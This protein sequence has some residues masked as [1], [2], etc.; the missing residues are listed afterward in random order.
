M[1]G[2]VYSSTLTPPII[3]ALPLSSLN[4]FPTSWSKKKLPLA[5]QLKNHRNILPQSTPINNL[6]LLKDLICILQGINGQFIKFSDRSL[7]DEKFIPGLIRE[8]LTT[9]AEGNS[10]G[11]EKG[12][13]YHGG[14]IDQPDRDLIH[15]VAE[16]GWLFKKINKVINGEEDETLV[17]DG[18][19][20]DGEEKKVRKIGM[21][22]QSL[23]AALKKEL[24]EYYRLI[25]MLEGELDN[26]LDLGQKEEE[27]EEVEDRKKPTGLRGLTLRR[28]LV[29][30]E[31]M[32]LRLRMMATLVDEA[33]M[34]LPDGGASYLLSF[35][36]SLNALSK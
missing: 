27:D 15:Q 26:T 18:G 30:T 25:A 32:R 31:E 2:N 10:K 16:M 29:L 4:P 34:V 9:G 17:N 8:T 20:E 14:R 35:S 28:L 7:R 12:I 23:H 24:I 11:W 3:P 36:L 5:V 19:Y 21:I 6:L 22:E 1:A 13:E 33:G